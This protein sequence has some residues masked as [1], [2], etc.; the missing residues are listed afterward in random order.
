M[1]EGK[2]LSDNITETCHELITWLTKAFSK[3]ET[4]VV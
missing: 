1:N 2:Q 3:N 4:F